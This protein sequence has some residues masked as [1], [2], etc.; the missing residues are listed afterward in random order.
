[1]PA[2]FITINW[3]QI[4]PVKLNNDADLINKQRIVSSTFPEKLIFDEKK[5]RTPRLN[6]VVSLAVL[7][8]KGSGK[9]KTG[10]IPK[11]WR[12]PDRWR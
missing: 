2:K 5:S 12:Y 1:M 7:S 3:I 10:Q 8:D 4:N 6:V 9:K 11:N